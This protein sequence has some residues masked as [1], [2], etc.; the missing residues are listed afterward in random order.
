MH[1]VADL[2]QGCE[3]HIEGCLMTQASGLLNYGRVP[4]L[5]TL[6]RGYT[7][8]EYC[9]PEELREAACRAQESIRGLQR[10]AREAGCVVG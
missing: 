9:I 2:W 3:V 7:P 4:L 10:A 6:S 8:C 5:D 1:F